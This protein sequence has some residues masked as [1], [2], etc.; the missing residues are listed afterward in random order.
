MSDV[1]WDTAAGVGPAANAVAA[2]DASVGLG[3]VL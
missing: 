3:A 2:P 1:L